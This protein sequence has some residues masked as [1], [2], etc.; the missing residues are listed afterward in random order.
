MHFWIL[1]YIPSLISLFA[2]THTVSPDGVVTVTPADRAPVSEGGSGT[3]TCSV[4]TGLPATQTRW[5]SPGNSLVCNENL[6]V[7][8]VQS[9]Q[10]CCVCIVHA[11][12]SL[13]NFLHFKAPILV[14]CNINGFIFLFILIQVITRMS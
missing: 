3:L 14:V 10:T 8:E 12:S 7:S 13:I 6:T 4:P 9:K 11:K 1:S 5:F 2:H